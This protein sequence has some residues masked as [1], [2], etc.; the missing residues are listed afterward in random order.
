MDTD[1]RFGR[2]REGHYT[3]K[4]V[5][6]LPKRGN[7]N[8]LFALRTPRLERFYR[9][10]VV[11]K[12]YETI[13]IGGAAFVPQDTS[14]S[15]NT[16]TNTLT[17]TFVDG[18]TRSVVLDIRGAV[19]TYTDETG[20]SKHKIGEYLNESNITADVN[21]TNTDLALTNNNLIYTRE[22]ST[23]R[24]LSLSPYINV[25]SDWNQTDNSQADFIENKPFIKIFS[26]YSYQ[27]NGSIAQNGRFTTGESSLIFAKTDLEGNDNST[28]FT[29]I[30]ENRLNI[31]F[32]VV[33]NNN[34]FSYYSVVSSVD[35]G[36]TF[37]LV[38][39]AFGGLSTG[40]FTVDDIYC[41][42]L[43]PIFRPQIPQSDWDETD[44][45]NP[46]FILNK[47]TITGGTTNLGYTAGASNGVVTSST[48]TDAT[49][50]LGTSS[51]AG[52]MPANFYQ[53]GTFTPTLL[54]LNGVA[55][56]TYTTNTGSYIRIGN[57]V[58]FSVIF[59]GIN[60]TGTPTGATVMDALPLAVITP[61][62]GV[63]YQFNWHINSSGIS[64]SDLGIIKPV[65]TANNRVGF[66]EH[67]QSALIN[68]LQFTTGGT[69]RISGTYRTNV[70]TP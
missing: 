58:H 70:F 64:D 2:L 40:P 15:F 21:E 17:A 61:S 1:N 47:P 6:S 60:Q 53:E 3:I 27:A 35:T 49:I 68:N 32:S 23:Q 69:L 63:D 43:T 50:P 45:G 18:T 54:D 52:L 29:E 20:V 5:V 41:I 39:S 51:N 10:D 57:N 59:N 28:F 36:T 62:A 19:T 8:W 7:A 24:T 9:W 22:D 42:G 38:V 65:V 12:K 33:E 44:S 25:Q 11:E 46:A 48:G 31:I 13:E 55:S 4:R 16:A 26:R 66:L 67:N 37:T 14:L 30:Q 56:F 34:S